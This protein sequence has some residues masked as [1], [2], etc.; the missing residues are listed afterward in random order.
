MAALV[1]MG[2]AGAVDPGITCLHARDGR[3]LA[4][5]VATYPRI[6]ASRDGGLTW[7]T[8]EATGPPSVLENCPAHPPVWTL[9]TPDAHYRFTRGQSIARSTDGGRTWQREV[10][11][12]ITQAR[13]AY[14]RSKRSPVPGEAELY[15][16]DVVWDPRHGHVIAAMGPDGV[17]VHTRE[18]GW[19]WVVVDHYGFEP[20]PP[21]PQMVALVRHELWLA[22]LLTALVFSTR[23][24]PGASRWLIPPLASGWLV[25][26]ATV[27]SRPALDA[28]LAFMVTVPLQLLTSLFTL[29]LALYHARRLEAGKESALPA[30]AVGAAFAMPYV[31]WDVGI[32]RTYDAAMVT[33]L[34]VA[35]LAWAVGWAIKRKNSSGFDDNIPPT[36]ASAMES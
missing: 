23:R 19:R 6:F 26:G 20:P 25:W 36:Q 8:D 15:P 1:T 3:V 12:E 10:D 22:L 2:S 29:P 35:A 27:L 17:L 14:N 32:V 16:E 33:A 11:L 34:G 24:A 9:E 13:M 7:E 18:E 30:I 4:F 5:N 21:A 31:A 28:G